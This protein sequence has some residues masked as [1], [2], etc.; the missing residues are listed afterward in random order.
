MTDAW[1]NTGFTAVGDLL[2]SV[3]ST[4]PA[5][6]PLQPVSPIKRRL[7]ESAEILR[8]SG[9]IEEIGFQHSVLCQTSL[10]Y[11]AT[12]ER[13]WEAQNGNVMLL[14]QAG[15]AYDPLRKQWVEL[16]L[17]FG[18]KARLILMYLNSEAIRTQ[19][20]VIDAGDS[21]TA[22]LRQLQGREPNGDEI[23]KFKQQ[24]AA[25]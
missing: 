2:P 1:K 20:P 10:P 24:L 23:R 8:Q 13:R 22:F 16:P 17:P 14:V 21:M 6:E 4:V 19:S 15:E 9:D 18:P 5:L 3:I 11:R 7:I 12:H 25:L